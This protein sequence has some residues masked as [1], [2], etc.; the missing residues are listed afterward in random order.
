MPL[1]CGAHCAANCQLAVSVLFRSRLH[2]TPDAPTIINSSNGS[3][4]LNPDAF[5]PTTCFGMTR[6]ARRIARMPSSA[7]LRRYD[8]EPYCLSTLDPA[9]SSPLHRRYK[10]QVLVVDEVESL[11]GKNLS[12]TASLVSSLTRRPHR[13][14]LDISLAAFSADSSVIMLRATMPSHRLRITG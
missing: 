8:A 7:Q 11:L 4:S 14:S 9:A 1:E 10:S 6:L 13:T 3:N 5:H 2:P 12:G